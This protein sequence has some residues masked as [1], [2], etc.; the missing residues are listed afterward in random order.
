VQAAIVGKSKS[1]GSFTEIIG[2]KVGKGR[3]V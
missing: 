3:P 2:A 1:P